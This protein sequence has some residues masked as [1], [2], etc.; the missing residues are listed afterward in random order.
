MRDM[1]TAIIMEMVKMM[2]SK[3]NC[4]GRK[5]DSFTNVRK[6]DEWSWFSAGGIFGTLFLTFSTSWSRIREHRDS[7]IKQRSPVRAPVVIA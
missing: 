6:S 4:R 5:R 1:A 3:N 7:R 2:G